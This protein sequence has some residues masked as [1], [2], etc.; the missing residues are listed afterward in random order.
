MPVD[1]GTATGVAALAAIAADKV[2]AYFRGDFKKYVE[3]FDA[4]WVALDKR[5][6]KLNEDF[7][8]MSAVVSKSHEL[9]R[10]HVTTIASTGERQIELLRE[11]I[12][13]VRDLQDDVTEMRLRQKIE[14][15]K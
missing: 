13:I 4:M 8:T 9:I 1:P 12:G 15:E 5:T 11:L 14:G 7:V 2:W 10:E 6:A 3:R